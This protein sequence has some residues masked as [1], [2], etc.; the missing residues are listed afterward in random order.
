MD[1]E[2]Q[3]VANRRVGDA[4]D[5]HGST[6]HFGGECRAA[7]HCRQSFRDP[8]RS[9][10]GAHELPGVECDRVAGRELVRPL[11]RPQAISDRLYRAVHSVVSAMWRRGEPGTA[12][13]RAHRPRRGRWRVATDRPG[14]ADGKF[15]PR[16]ARLGDGCIRTGS[17]RGANHWPD[18]GRLDHGQLFVALDF[19]HQYSHWHSRNIHGEYFRRGPALHPRSKAWPHRLPRL[20]L[21]GACSGNYAVSPRQ[22]SGGR[23]VRVFVH[24]RV[25][26]PFRRGLNRVHNLGTKIE[27]ANRRFARARQSEL[28]RGHVADDCHG[29]SAVWND[30][31]LAFVSADANGLSGGGERHG[32]KPARL[33][34]GH[35]NADRGAANQSS[36]RAISGD[37]WIFGAGLL[38]LSVQQDQSRDF[39]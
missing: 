3:S 15:P 5:V 31:S 36:P 9:H 20:R 32:G 21:D 38:D 26:N 17:G 19:L 23:V 2:F 6:G 18:T 11:F 35:L 16:K 29:C 28:R 1:P 33:W 7:A 30:R 37:V 12:D 4:R 10:V 34:R 39:D 24:Y 22:G 27:G 13:R 25:C 14:G 8:R